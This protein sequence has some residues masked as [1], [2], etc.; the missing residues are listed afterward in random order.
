MINYHD[1]SYFSLHTDTY[2]IILVAVSLE[3][4]HSI[5]DIAFLLMSQ[6]TDKYIYI[7]QKI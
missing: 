6:N 2:V 1:F 5:I 4:V 7:H 3:W